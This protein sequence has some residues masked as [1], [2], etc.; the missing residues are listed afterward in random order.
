MSESRK[1]ETRFY[2]T[3]AALIDTRFGEADVK[4]AIIDKDVVKKLLGTA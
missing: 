1:S 2:F 3:D 4:S